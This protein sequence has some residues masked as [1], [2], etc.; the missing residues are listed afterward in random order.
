MGKIT[1]EILTDERPLCR[2]CSRPLK[3]S[4]LRV[5]NPPRATPRLKWGSKGDGYFCQT[6]CAYWWAIQYWENKEPR[7]FAE[8]EMRELRRWTRSRQRI[9]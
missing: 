5:G 7:K 4:S 2:Y 9:G 6:M 1:E 8:D 3:L